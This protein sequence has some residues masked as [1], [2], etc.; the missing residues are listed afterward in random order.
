MIIQS[1]E[2]TDVRAALPSQDPASELI[3][4]TTPSKAEIKRELPALLSPPRRCANAD[5]LVI[6]GR[7]PR[8]TENLL[9]SLACLDK[10]DENFQ[11]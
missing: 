5:L 2:A 8:K 9:N 4:G 6:V 7:S 11:V 10:E 3:L 1:I